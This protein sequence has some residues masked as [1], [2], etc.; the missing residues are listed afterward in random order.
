MPLR[1]G[2]RIVV[3]S[4]VPEGKGVS[5]SAALEVATMHAAAQSLGV[6]V[7]PRDLA[8]LCQRAENL[9]VG[10]PCGVMDQMTCVFG[11]RGLLALL[12]QPA[13]LQ[14][15]A[16]RP[17]DSSSGGSIPACATPW[18]APTTAR[19]A[20]APSWGSESCGPG[21]SVDGVSRQ[22]RA[23]GLRTRIAAHLPDEMSGDAFLARYGHIGDSVTTVH[24]GRRYRVC[25]PTA[26]PVCERRVPRSSV[27]C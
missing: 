8:L 15:P 1:S 4:D 22:R 14:S 11:D 13:E 7:T 25:A 5:S 24:P 26:H 3:V 27:V 23:G 2:L 6:D 20:W 17:A 12:C 10:A 9:V 19:S 18:A 16:V 21:G